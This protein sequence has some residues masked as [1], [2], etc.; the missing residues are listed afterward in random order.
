MKKSWWLEASSTLTELWSTTTWPIPGEICPTQIPLKVTHLYQ[1]TL[2]LT[3]H[4]VRFR[5]RNNNLYSQCFSMWKSQRVP[6]LKF[7]FKT[8]P[9]LKNGNHLQNKTLADWNSEIPY[10]TLQYNDRGSFDRNSLDRN[11]DLSVDRNF[12]NQLTEIFD[13]FHLTELFFPNLT[14][15]NIT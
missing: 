7:L 15:P 9:R 1:Q 10:K 2:S 4:L 13:T 3:N 5:K 8:I 11:C 6:Q 12:Y 14:W